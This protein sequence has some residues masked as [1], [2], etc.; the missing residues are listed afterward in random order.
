MDG[1][2]AFKLEDGEHL[3]L[4][5]VL[6][7]YSACSQCRLLQKQLSV[8]LFASWVS[9]TQKCFRTALITLIGTSICSASQ[10]HT[11]IML[12]SNRTHVEW[13][14]RYCFT[15]A[16]G[17]HNATITLQHPQLALATLPCMLH[18]ASRYS[19][20][21]HVEQRNLQLLMTQHISVT[22]NSSVLASTMC[23]HG[24]CNPSIQGC[25]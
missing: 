22:A 21:Q 11:L 4:V 16:S 25:A 17:V 14:S 5:A 15:N 12:I 13:C 24:W 18:S 20:M 8:G 7:W 9:C 1:Q 2:V 6:S 19:N 10:L 3:C 23:S